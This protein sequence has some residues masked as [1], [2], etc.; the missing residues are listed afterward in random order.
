MVFDDTV[1]AD[2]AKEGPIM[3]QTLSVGKVQTVLG[4]VDA[5]AHFRSRD[6]V[7]PSPRLASEFRPFRPYIDTKLF[8]RYGQCSRSHERARGH[9]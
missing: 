3:R 5:C 4:V 1:R 6:G 2:T 9:Q 7:L 8:A